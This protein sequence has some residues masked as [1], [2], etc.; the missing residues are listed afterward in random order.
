MMMSV[1]DA[2][3]G[4]SLVGAP[5]PQLVVRSC[6]PTEQYQRLTQVFPDLTLVAAGARIESNTAY[7]LSGFQARR[8]PRVDPLWREFFDLHLSTE[9]CRD[10][11]GFVA[12]WLRRIHPSLERRAGKSISEM[13][14]AARGELG[15]EEADLTFDCQFGINSPVWSQTST[16]RTPHIDRPRK[17]FNALLYCRAPG[18]DTPGGELELYETVRAPAYFDGQ[19]VAAS[20]IRRAVSIPYEANTLVLFCNSPTSVHGVA[21][22]PATPHSRRYINFLCEYRESLFETPQMSRL[23]RIAERSRKLVFG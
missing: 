20:G 3:R 12:D 9:F 23:H 5:F 16:P 11:V 8:D 13:S 6:L 17:L 10:W 15:S 18:D 19:N 2:V 14:I 1:L 22:R 4:H 21:P 7:I